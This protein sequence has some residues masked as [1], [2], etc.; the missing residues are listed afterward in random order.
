MQLVQILF[1][2]SKLAG[3][4][5]EGDII[6]NATTVFFSITQ[7]TM[8]PHVPDHDVRVPAG[9]PIVAP[10]SYA[11]P[12]YC[13]VLSDPQYREGGAAELGRSEITVD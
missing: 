2:K 5:R 13:E 6:I 3:L 7:A 10:P 9:L 11:F 1:H 8:R 4:N 12:V